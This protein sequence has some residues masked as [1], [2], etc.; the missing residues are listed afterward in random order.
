MAHFIPQTK[1][2]TSTYT[3]PHNT[4]TY[5]AQQTTPTTDHTPALATHTLTARTRDIKPTHHSDLPQPITHSNTHAPP[6]KTNCPNNQHP[7]TP[8]KHN[9]PEAQ[10]TP[11]HSQPHHTTNHNTHTTPTQPPRPRTHETTKNNQPFVVFFGCSFCIVAVFPLVFFVYY[12]L[13]VDTT[14]NTHVPPQNQ[15][16]TTTLATPQ[17][18]S[19]PQS[20]KPATHHIQQRPTHTNNPQHHTITPTSTT[21]H[22]IPNKN[23]LC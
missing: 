8:K 23:M 15:K 4:P 17:P 10:R 13:F 9:T 20:R 11:P 1:Y 18:N 12:F 5:P 19:T 6:T 7:P 16:P 14:T 21:T 22:F 3:Q 2:T